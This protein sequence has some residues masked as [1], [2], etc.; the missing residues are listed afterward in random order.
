[1]NRQVLLRRRPIG[2][3]AADDFEIVERPLAIVPDGGVLRRTIY[4]SL[5]PYMRGRM[6]DA[7]SYA[8]SVA[9]GQAMVGHTVSQVVES[10]NPAF[11]AGDFVAGYDGWQD[12]GL[13]SG[14][15][16]RTI[17]PAS[18]PISTAIGVLGMPGLTAYVGLFDIGKP[19]AGETVVISAAAGA[20]GSVVGQLARIEGCRTVGITGSKEKCDYV[21][22]ELGFD[23]CV[24][25]RELEL[26]DAIKTACPDGIDVYFEN[27]GGA[28][29]AAVLPLLNI[30]ARIPLCGL[31]SEYNATELPQGVSLRPLL[32]KRV[33]LKGFIVLDHQ[34]R[35]ADF[36]R[37]CSQWLREGRLKYREDV[38]EGLESAPETFLRLFDGRNFGKLLVR[39]SPDP[40]RP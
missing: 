12:F 18:S 22:N 2:R 27:V 17:D 6:S 37:D 31:I 7:A 4:L 36:L 1:M 29:F 38:V 20:V 11:K 15:D 10:K 5:D 23:A 28:V 26:H 39:V 9:I 14:S 21:V 16:L 34:A 25:H 8:Q 33:L 24:S 40:T 3:P 13:S 19:K 32:F 35:M 30:N